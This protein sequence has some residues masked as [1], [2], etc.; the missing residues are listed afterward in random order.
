[1]MTK[2]YF[3]NLLIFLFLVSVSFSRGAEIGI[4]NNP[5]DKVIVFGNSKIGITL[6]YNGRCAITNL[7]VKGQ[8]VI[9]RQDGIYSEIKTTNG[10]WSTLKLKSDP[11]ISFGKNSVKVSNI[12]YGMIEEP[13]IE[14]WN[15]MIT[16]GDIKFEIERNFPRPLT[17]EEA[18]FPSVNFDSMNTWNGA[19]LG[20]GGLAWFYLFNQKLC[21]Y[22]VHSNASVFW[23]SA[24]GNALSLG[25]EARGK[26]VALKYS[27]ADDDHLNFS[28]AV[29]DQ[30]LTCRYE[31][32]KRSRFIRGK[33]NVWDRFTQVSG[34]YVQSITLSYVNYNQAY[35]RG[36]FVGENGKQITALLNTIARIGVIDDKHFGGN[37]WHTP[38]GPICLHEQYIARFGIGIDD[39]H[40][41]KGYK[42]CLD[43]YRDNAIQSNG[44]V[45]SR[46]AYLD[47]DAM[48][49][50]VTDKGF[51]EAQ[52]GYLMDSN[53]DFVS[54][55]AE[56]FNLT[57]DINWVAKHKTSCE[58]VL[59]FMLKRDSNGNHLV[60]MMTNSQAEKRGSDW[61]DII[62][63][64]YENAFVNAK[65]YHALTLWAN[66]EKQLNDP[67]RESYYSNYASRLKKS[68]NKSIADG[69]FWNPANK[70]YV[71]WLDKDHAAHGD[72]L[73]VPVNLMAIVYGICD[74]TL[75]RN[76]ILDKIEEQTSAEH[77]FFWPI[78]LYPYAV[79]EGNDWQ[80]PFPNYENGDIFLSWGSVGVEAYAN[81]KPEIALK[82]IDNVLNRYEKDGLAFQRYGR[83]GQKG[84]GDDILSGN[85]LALVGLYQAIYGIN[86]LYNRLYLNPHITDKLSGTEL[87]YNYRHDKLTV[88]LTTNKYS[89]SNEQ[90]KVTSKHDFGFYAEKNE[91]TFFNRKEDRYSLKA[92]TNSA[93]SI[94]IGKWD[95]EECTW[96]QSVVNY[97][98]KVTYSIRV[99]KENSDY[100][101]T[102]GIKR[103]RAR[104]D[105][106]GELKFV[107][108]GGEQ[109]ITV[110][111]FE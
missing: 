96:Q 73:V 38:Y 91:V 66:V 69:G 50:T 85:S 2:N 95:N 89:I 80:F 22:G 87:V 104:S 17:I 107:I 6:D 3:Q 36:H 60:E 102:Y 7:T 63:A 79:G 10:S 105:G 111:P 46:W 88:G 83:V 21:T 49:G 52:W 82:Y 68:F 28:I 84:L 24:T 45:I 27:R 31:H 35:N 29:S 51:Y 16:E 100:T 8:T 93:L 26:H 106:S 59:E 77:L 65:L 64:S 56:L 42:D 98:G 76:A 97:K 19:F 34:K 94:E 25:V 62:W 5:V 11:T 61:I 30:E 92:E 74:D 86:P 47:E 1:M 75:R 55:V 110:N 23:N 43:F 40:Y 13:V 57:G 39:E 70:W 81:Y 18:S 109:K 33:T 78:C 54:N 101:I 15:F 72:N 32:E 12:R 103:K 37:S 53:P 71:H 48:P 108:E 41:T 14:T 58:K 9:T 67:E 44:R 4:T 20:Y 99:L 90:F